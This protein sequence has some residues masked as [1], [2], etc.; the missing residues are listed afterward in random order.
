MASTQNQKSYTG[1]ERRAADR[2]LT[3]AR[4]IG[5]A[6]VAASFPRTRVPPFERDCWMPVLDR[7]PDV[8]L[9]P[10]DG[11]VWVDVRGLPRTIWAAFLEIEIEEAARVG[12]FSRASPGCNRST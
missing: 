4:V 5:R 3:G 12:A 8:T 10:L 6:R 11:Y 7:N 9:P 2:Q 1:L